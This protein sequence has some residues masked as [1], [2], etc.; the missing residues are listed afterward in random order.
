MSRSIYPV[1]AL[2]AD[3]LLTTTPAIRKRL[4]LSRPVPRELVANCLRLALQAPTGGSR[5]TW[6]FLVITEAEKR[7]AIGEQDRRPDF[8]DLP[9]EEFLGPVCGHDQSDEQTDEQEC[10]ICGH[11]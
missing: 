11:G 2:S 1:E 9:A 10:D 3:K 6:H 5:Q 8:A 4:D 7:Q